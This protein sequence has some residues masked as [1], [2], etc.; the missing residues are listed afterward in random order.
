MVELEKENREL[1]ERLIHIE[2]ELVA[3]RN[4]M[5]NGMKPQQTEYQPQASPREQLA[6][7]APSGGVTC[8]TCSFGKDC[9]CLNSVVA[10][11]A[12]QPVHIPQTTEDK[13]DD[14][15]D[16]K[17]GLCSSNSCLCED[18]GIRGTR[19]LQPISSLPTSPTHGIKRKRS[20]TP[21]S[22]PIEPAP[23]TFPMEID[24]TSTFSSVTKNPQINVLSTDS[25]GFC[26]AGTPCVC[27]PNTLPPIQVDTSTIVAEA[28]PEALR[29]SGG[30]RPQVNDVKIPVG[31][32]PNVG[33]P[34]T[35]ASGN[36][37]C[38]GEPGIPLSHIIEG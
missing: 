28:Y 9:A 15:M 32:V 1:R 26:S 10:E 21:S 14:T 12:A 33:S 11:S 18:L 25:C 29:R 30:R 35:I 36:G 4:A 6:S 8:E 38:T 22:S 5:P 37:G 23:E 3:M 31:P 17:C 2:A 7:P 34:M 19:Q 24:F 13:S 27:L 20:G 16:E